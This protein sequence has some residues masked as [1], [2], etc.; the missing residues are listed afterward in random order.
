MQ[1]KVVLGFFPPAP[2]SSKKQYLNVLSIL[3]ILVK[4]D[5]V[6]FLFYLMCQWDANKK[7]AK[8][9]KSIVTC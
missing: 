4:W 1:F 5:S 8:Q 3:I 6:W 9:S 7:T 2:Y